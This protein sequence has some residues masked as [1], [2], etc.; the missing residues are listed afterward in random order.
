MEE[1]PTLDTVV[2]ADELVKPVVILR[3]S[4]PGINRFGNNGKLVIRIMNLSLIPNLQNPPT[5]MVIPV[6]AQ[7][8]RTLERPL[9]TDP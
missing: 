3:N 8:T 1:T 6:P 7:D 4:L 9:L 2:Q 5:D